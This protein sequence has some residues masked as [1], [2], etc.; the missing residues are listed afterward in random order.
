MVTRVRID[1][2]LALLVLQG[3]P[4]PVATLL[5]G[6]RSVRPLGGTLLSLGFR[7]W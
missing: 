4:A 6:P 3:D 7:V 1:P 2:W 5:R